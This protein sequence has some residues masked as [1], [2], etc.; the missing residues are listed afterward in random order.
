MLAEPTA[1]GM[2]VNG[3]NAPKGEQCLV[4][5]FDGKGD[6][7][8]GLDTCSNARED[9]QY[10]HIFFFNQEG[11][12]EHANDDD[13]CVIAG[14]QGVVPPNGIPVR[15]GNCRAA[16]NAGDGRSNWELSM[17]NQLVMSKER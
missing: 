1:P 17:S 13:M 4:R 11:Q 3:I 9:G 5:K 6:T 12:L 14:S 16:L 15:L 10:S 7:G 2:L 8:L